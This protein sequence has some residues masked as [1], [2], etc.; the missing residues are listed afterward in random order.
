MIIGPSDV[1]QIFPGWVLWVSVACL[2]IGNAMM[3]YVSMMGVFKR[4]RYRP[5]ALGAR[6]PV[7]LAVA[8]AS[9][10]TRRSGS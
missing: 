10:P 9:P 8:L 7:L 5:G 4:H 6:Q 3:I 1:A 2:I